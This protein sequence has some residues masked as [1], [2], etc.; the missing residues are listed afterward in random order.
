M[1]YGVLLTAIILS[2]PLSPVL[3][4]EALDHNTGWFVP[5]ESPRSLPR[6]AWGPAR[7]SAT[8]YRYDVLVKEASF[9]D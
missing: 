3:A 6:S 9:S 8:V 1:I 2:L 5:S 4:C 7:T